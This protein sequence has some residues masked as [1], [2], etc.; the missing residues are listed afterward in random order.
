MIEQHLAQYLSRYLGPS[1]SRCERLETEEEF[2]HLERLHQIVVSATCKTRLLVLQGIACSQKDHGRFV[3]HLCAQALTDLQ[4]VDAR[5]SDVENVDIEPRRV[6]QIEKRLSMEGQLDRTTPHL[7]VVRHS[8][9]QRKTVFEQKYPHGDAAR[10][11][12]TRW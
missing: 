10:T 7:Q 2:F 9:S 8:T 11:M 4:P 1:P 12:T 6:R 5:N 3:A